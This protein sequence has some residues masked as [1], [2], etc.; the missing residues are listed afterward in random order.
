MFG[1]TEG[2]RPQQKLSIKDTSEVVCDTCKGNVFNQGM[3]LRK[4][5]SLLTGQPKDSYLP[6]D[7]FYCVKCHTVNDCFIP[8][9]LKNK[10]QLI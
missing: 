4:V 5:S 6:I 7:A 9:E 10:I 2:H 1:S 8:E 3:F